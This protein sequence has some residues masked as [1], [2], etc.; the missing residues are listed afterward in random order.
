MPLHTVTIETIGSQLATTVVVGADRP[1][2]YEAPHALDFIPWVPDG[3]RA[4]GADAFSVIWSDGQRRRPA[5][6]TAT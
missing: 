3:V 6:N 1:P 4:I 2:S 5:V